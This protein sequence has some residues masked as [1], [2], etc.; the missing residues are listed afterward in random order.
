VL[1][2]PP[3]KHEN[4]RRTTTYGE[5]ERKKERKSDVF[6]ILSSDLAEILVYF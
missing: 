2:V 6:G 3:Q 4:E 1:G 5:R